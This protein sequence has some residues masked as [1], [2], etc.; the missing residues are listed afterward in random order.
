MYLM[1]MIIAVDVDD[2]LCDLNTEWLQR[3]NKDFDDNLTKNKITEWD[4]SLFVK[5]ECGKYIF[6]YL[7]DTYLYDNVL[8]L[9]GALKG[10]NIIRDMGHRIIF[11]TTPT[12]KSAGRKFLWLLN[13]SFV[14]NMKDY[15][16]VTDKSL[17]RANM[18]IDDKYENIKAFDGSGVLYSQPWNLKY[19]YAPRVK[20]WI[21]VVKLIELL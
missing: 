14:S 4:I 20:N 18:L 7:N 8:P 12:I 19:D 9:P 6:E 1:G 17:V 2:V 16:E 10:I 3:Y 11:V 15:I 5:P 13:N 21:G